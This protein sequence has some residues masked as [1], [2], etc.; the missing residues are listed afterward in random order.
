MP[1]N[2]ADKMT[3]RII[4]S[5]KGSSENFPRPTIN[6]KPINK[7]RASNKYN[8]SLI[9]VTLLNIYKVL[10]IED[11]IKETDKKLEFITRSRFTILTASEKITP[12]I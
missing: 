11:T 9:G 8:L 12:L 5:N 10:R 2:Y 6:I 1:S 7:I 4:I 3:L